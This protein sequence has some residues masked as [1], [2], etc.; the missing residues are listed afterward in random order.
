MTTIL[1]SYI[2]SI[3]VLS[4]CMMGIDK[5]KAKR[6]RWRISERTLF[7]ISIFG[8]SIGALI[9][10]HLF[11]HK[12]KKRHFLIGLPVILVLQLLCSLFLFLRQQEQKGSP[13]T[14]VTN[15]LALI[16]NLDETT[17]QN[18]VSYENM[19]SAPPSDTKIGKETTEAV[20]LFF[21]NFKYE[22]LSEEIVGDTAT[23]QVEI[24][25]IDTHKLAKDLCLALT[26]RS[27]NLD[28]ISHVPKKMN[29]YFS[30]LRDTLKNNTYNLTSS[31]A[32]FHLKQDRDFWI[33]QSDSDLQNQLVSDFISWINNPN[34]LTPEE[35]L[36][37]YMDEF[38][39]LTAQQW[40]EYLNVEDIFSTGS[41]S[42][43]Q[44][45]DQTYMEKIS[46][47]FDYSIDT[48]C[49]NGEKACAKITINSIDMPTVLEVYKEKLLDYA[50]T[51]A[52]ITRDETGLADDSARYL[53]EAL[54]ETTSPA[55]FP[56]TAE[57]TNDGHTWQLEITEELTNAFLGNIAKALETFNS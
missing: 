35:V 29:D 8:G 24:T 33:I 10:M 4:F 57:L 21:K 26:A 7:L 40:L 22:I 34:L 12:T 28:T 27:L 18:F 56:V 52:S 5:W 14:A 30:L 25:N 17:I 1:F 55:A 48:C 41:S 2:A 50:Q 42:Y 37:I 15:E 31:T 46:E 32:T 53:L 54:E 16:Q 43:Y 11:H 19:M 49:I 45:V 38:A 23:V 44:D 36:T 3:N 51:S 13:V 39:S 6:G 9:G 47:Y 20:H